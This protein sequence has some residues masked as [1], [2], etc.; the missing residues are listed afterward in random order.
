MTISVRLAQKSDVVA[1]TELEYTLFNTDQISKSQFY[2][3]IRS[4]RNLLYLAHDNHQV[5]GYILLF[6]RQKSARIYSLA[7]LPAYQGKGIAHNLIQYAINELPNTIAMLTLEVNTSNIGAIHLYQKLG[8]SIYK[9]LHNYY[10][11][12]ENAYRMKKLGL[13]KVTAHF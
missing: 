7:V 2:Y 1:L 3:H 10:L 12:G 8:F 9:I 13:D 11:N 5:I 6:V 4:P